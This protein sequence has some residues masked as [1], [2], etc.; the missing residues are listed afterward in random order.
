MDGS[1]WSRSSSAWRRCLSSSLPFQLVTSLYKAL[2]AALRL[3]RITT[4]AHKHRERTLPT[5]PTFKQTSRVGRDKKITC[6]VEGEVSLSST[7]VSQSGCCSRWYTYA[8]LTTSLALEDANERNAWFPTEKV[9]SSWVISRTQY[10]RRAKEGVKMRQST[11]ICHF[12]VCAT[13]E[14]TVTSCVCETA[15]RDRARRRA[16]GWRAAAPGGTCCW[17]WTR[18]WFAFS[19][20]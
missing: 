3:S 8:N 19:C 15:S 14:Q 7:R 16:S 6:G 9:S 12:P 11:W 10:L 20:L 17:T 4:W 18:R 1:F 13:C 2:P 5:T